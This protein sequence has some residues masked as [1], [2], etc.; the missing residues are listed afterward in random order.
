MTNTQNLKLQTLL[1]AWL[2]HDDL[3]KAGA[4]IAELSASRFRL[5]DAR[6]DALMAIS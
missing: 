6:C 2:S 5:D 4:D 3:R 1:A